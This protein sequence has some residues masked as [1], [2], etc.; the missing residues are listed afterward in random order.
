MKVSSDCPLTGKKKRRWAN[1]RRHQNPAGKGERYDY[2]PICRGIGGYRACD[3]CHGT[4]MV[5][6]NRK[7]KT[8][9]EPRAR[10]AS[11]QNQKVPAGIVRK[12][13]RVFGGI[14]QPY[15]PIA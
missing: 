12:K 14:K 2:C 5:T 4:G 11:R 9:N 10:F 3:K 6:I 15:L 13:T 1:A 7:K 8:S